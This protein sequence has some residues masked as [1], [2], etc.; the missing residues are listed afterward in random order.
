MGFEN[1]FQQQNN[2]WTVLQKKVLFQDLTIRVGHLMVNK[3]VPRGKSKQTM[4]PE[5]DR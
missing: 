2:L 1:L 5:A 3:L 4:F